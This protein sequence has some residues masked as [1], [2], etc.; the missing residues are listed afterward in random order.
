MEILLLAIKNID[1]LTEGLLETLY[2]TLV[3]AVFA[4]A[5]GITLGV[6][7]DDTGGSWRIVWGFKGGGVPTSELPSHLMTHA[8]RKDATIGADRVLYHAHPSAVVAMTGVLPAD[9]R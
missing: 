3:S 9:A 1:I 6:E 2:M 4:Y 5:D 7:L 8:V